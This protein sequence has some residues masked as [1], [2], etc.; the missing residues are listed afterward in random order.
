ML[1]KLFTSIVCHLTNCLSYHR[2][3][4]IIL[5]IMVKTLELSSPQVNQI[6][7]EIRCMK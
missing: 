4:Y 5:I 7:N 6:D 2:H 1:Q 3:Q